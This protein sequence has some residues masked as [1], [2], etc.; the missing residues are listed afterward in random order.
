MTYHV[1]VTASGRMSLPAELRKQLGLSGGGDLF[2][3]NTEN[4][5]VL[6]TVAQAVA[7]AQA[8]A[9]RYTGDNPESS[10]DAFLAA[11]RLDSGE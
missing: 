4:G 8:I 1:K 6:R 11:R 7:N 9:R 5:V 10:V 3:E 2:V